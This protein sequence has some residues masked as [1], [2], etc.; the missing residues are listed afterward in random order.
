MIHYVV[1]SLRDDKSDVK[2][3]E[4]IG[5]LVHACIHVSACVR[6]CI[7]HSVCVC[8]CMHICPLAYDSTQ[9]MDTLCEQN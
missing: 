9:E 6:A 5:C 7:S 4:C 1:I 3:E 8:A 2:L